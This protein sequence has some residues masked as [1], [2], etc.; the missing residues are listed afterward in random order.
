MKCNNKL[1]YGIYHTT[2][3]SDTL[4]YKTSNYSTSQNN[5]TFYSYFLRMFEVLME[6]NELK[7]KLNI[8]RQLDKNNGYKQKFS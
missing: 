4:I 8:T 3:Q 2:T 1:K 6:E 5:S 7:T